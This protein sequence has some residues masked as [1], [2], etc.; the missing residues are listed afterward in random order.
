M[1]IRKRIPS[2]IPLKRIHPRRILLQ[3]CITVQVESI[4]FENRATGLIPLLKK[5]LTKS[6]GR[7]NTRRAVLC[8]D[9]TVHV[10]REFWDAGWGCGYVP[11]FS[12]TLYRLSDRMLIP[13]RR[14]R[15]FLMVC[16]A[17]M[18]QP[19]QPMYFPLLDSPTSPGVRNLQHWIEDA[20]RCGALL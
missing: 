11:T 16:T 15:N 6:H 17:L 10:H 12:P 9:R 1:R 20:W 5:S 13:I 18:D 3:V 19:F 4:S 8:Y 7:G 14:Y 2:G